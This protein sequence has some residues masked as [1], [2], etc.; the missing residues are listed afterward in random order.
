MTTTVKCAV[1]DE[2]WD[3]RGVEDNDMLKWEAKLFWLGA[4]CPCCRG[5]PHKGDMEKLAEVNNGKPIDVPPWNPP[6]ADTHWQCSGCEVASAYDH[7]EEEDVWLGGKDVHYRNGIAFAYPLSFDGE[8]T[9]QP[10][11]SIGGEPYCDGCATE[12]GDCNG[13]IFARGELQGDTYDAGSAF[14]PEG[15]YRLGSALCID[16][17]ENHLNC[18]RGEE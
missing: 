15:Q 13:S 10:H 16:C 6:P 17:Y 18:E 7:E 8:P 2:P 5:G 12:C 1:C 4:G 3:S 11:H 9:Q 14:V